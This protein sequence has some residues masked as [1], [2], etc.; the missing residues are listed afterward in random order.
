MNASETRATVEGLEGR[1]LLAADPSE[2]T[3][4]NGTLFF[5][6]G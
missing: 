5:R 2:L 1:L 4:V 3:D 6:R